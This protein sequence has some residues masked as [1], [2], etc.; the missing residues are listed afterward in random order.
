[1]LP[2]LLVRFRQVHEFGKRI[3]RELERDE[4]DA[5]TTV[6]PNSGDLSVVRSPVLVT[7]NDLIL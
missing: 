3:L 6:K 2:P 5:R 1:M 4:G 7:G